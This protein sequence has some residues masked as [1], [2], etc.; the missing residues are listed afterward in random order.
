MKE[1]DEVEI[2]I[3]V[4]GGKIDVVV[5]VSKEE[6]EGDFDTDKEEVNP[7]GVELIIEEEIVGVETEV[8][9]IWDEVGVDALVG[10]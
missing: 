1:E 4:V 9:D 7:L 6:V 8:E 10:E 3:E 2:G 5:M